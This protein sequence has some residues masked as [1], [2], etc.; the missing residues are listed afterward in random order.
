VDRLGPA[1]LEALDRALVAALD[2]DALRF[3]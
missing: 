3:G 1:R 2:I